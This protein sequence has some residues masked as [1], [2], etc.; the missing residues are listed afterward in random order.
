M[1]DILDLF[2][3]RG[4]AIVDEIHEVLNVKNELTYGIGTEDVLDQNKCALGVSLYGKIAAW[5]DGEV[6]PL[7]EF[8]DALLANRQADRPASERK[9]VREQLAKELYDELPPI[10]REKLTLAAWTHYICERPIN[11]KTPAEIRDSLN[12]TDLFPSFMHELQRN[13]PDTYTKI[14]WMRQFLG[15]QK[16]MDTSLGMSNNVNYGRPKDGIQT[17]PFKANNK[18]DIANS[19]ERI[20]QASQDYLQLGLSRN[21]V[22]KF[23]DRLIQELREEMDEVYEVTGCTLLPDE[24]KTFQKFSNTFQGFDLLRVYKDPEEAA[25]FSQELQKRS[26]SKL[27]L[28]KDFILTKIEVPPLQVSATANDLVGMIG[29]VS[30]LS[31]TP[32]NLD[33]LSKKLDIS[34]ALTPGVDGRSIDF[35]LEAAQAGRLRVLALHQFDPK[36]PLQGLTSVG[37]FWQ[38]YDAIIDAGAYEKGIPNEKIAERLG[39]LGKGKGS[40]RAVAYVDGEENLVAQDFDSTQRTPLKERKDLSP[41]ERL[42]NYDQAHCSG[43]DIV[44]NPQARALVT[45]GK[46][47]WKD[48]AQAMNRMR[49]LSESGQQFDIAVSPDVAKLMDPKQQGLTPQRIIAFMID[50]QGDLE[51]QDNLRAE[52]KRINGIVPEAMFWDLVQQRR[53]GAYDNRF[54][55]YSKYLLQGTDDKPDQL[56]AVPDEGQTVDVLEDLKIEMKETFNDLSKY[57]PAVAAACEDVEKYTVLPAEKLPETTSTFAGNEQAELVTEPRKKTHLD[58][59][60]MQEFRK[61]AASVSHLK[62]DLWKPWPIGKPLRPWIDQFKFIGEDPALALSNLSPHFSNNLHL[63]ENFAGKWGRRDTFAFSEDFED[64]K[65]T[66]ADMTATTRSL[67]MHVLV[68]RN[69]EGATKA[70]LIDAA[71]YDTVIGQLFEKVLPHEWNAAVYDIRTPGSSILVKSPLKDVHNPFEH[72]DEVLSLLAQVKFFAGQYRLTGEEREAFQQWVGDDPQRIAELREL[73]EHRILDPECKGAY[74]AN[75]T[76]YRALH[77]E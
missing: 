73:Y 40:K 52:R 44:H 35:V 7:K 4:K 48:F 46:I 66:S 39:E 54:M 12:V 61:E 2:K 67:P 30:G 56:A 10:I 3:T 69:D 25:R 68:L 53:D 63:S 19:F 55:D 24:C 50:Y 57:Y 22:D 64:R 27:T 6:G 71:E 36:D 31:S 47:A 37:N 33:T 11:E 76:V 60:L 28:L 20:M 72:D 9:M 42:S 14:G 23:V 49:K 13:D 5:N 34:N 21:Q 43:L 65:I 74:Q 75:S 38:K 70:M 26:D 58:Q 62:V 15:D 18:A 77:P 8:A 59:E 51:A 29:E 16:A 32:W 45:I 1:G 41:G 17:I